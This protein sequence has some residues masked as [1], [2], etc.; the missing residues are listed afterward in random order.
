M[1]INAVP[2]PVVLL[3]EELYLVVLPKGELNE[4]GIRFYFS[5][6]AQ[7]EEGWRKT[8]DQGA[9]R[10]MAKWIVAEEKFSTGQRNAVVCQNVTGRT[11]ERIAQSKRAR[12]GS[13]VIVD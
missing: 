10:F 1:T 8:A 6:A 2:T 3:K 5:C 11:K 7:D 9:Q 4:S 12:A 13:L